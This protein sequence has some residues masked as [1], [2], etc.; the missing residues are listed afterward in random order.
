[1]YTKFGQQRRTI[2]HD[3]SLTQST[4]DHLSHIARLLLQFS[5]R[6]CLSVLAFVDQARRNL[7]ADFVD[8]WSILLLQQDFWTGL[9]FQNCNDTHAVDQ[10]VLGS[11]LSLCRF[12]V[13]DLIVR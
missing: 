12:P 4:F 9:L 13:S 3:R 8:R 2:E 1:M 10:T 11:G 7:D 6:T 5:D